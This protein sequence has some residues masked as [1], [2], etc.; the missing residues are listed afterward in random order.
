MVKSGCAA[1]LSDEQMRVSLVTR[2]NV[3]FWG[4][5]E[6][7][8]SSY[9]VCVLP[10]VFLALYSSF[11][12]FSYSL[13][14]TH[15]QCNVPFVYPTPLSSEGAGFVGSVTLVEYTGGRRVS[16]PRRM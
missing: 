16:L 11:S 14:Q 10:T 6:I 2:E 3:T 8:L 4:Q 9:T 5:G 13:L 15:A 1:I 7:N 12:L